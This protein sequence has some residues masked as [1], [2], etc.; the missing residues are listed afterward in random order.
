V[1]GT[2]G[3]DRCDRPGPDGQCHGA[4]AGGPEGAEVLGWTRSGRAVEGVVSAGPDLATL[5]AGS[6]VLILSLFDD[7]A[8]AEMLDAL[9]RL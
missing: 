2:H 5:V 1:S 9:L 7:A 8:V 3:T 4:Q 6:D